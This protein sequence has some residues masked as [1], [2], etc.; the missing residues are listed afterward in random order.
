MYSTLK[1]V[2]SRRWLAL[3]GAVAAL[4]VA[5]A[6][7]GGS[8]KHGAASG[9]T[10]ATTASSSARSFPELR[11]AWPAIDHLDP[12]L[13]YGGGFTIVYGVYASLLS[14]RHANGPDG[15]ELVPALAEAL[16]KI[17]TDGRTY[18]FTLRD[19]LHYSDGRP[20]KA[21]D[22]RYG[23][24][25]LFRVNSPG[26]G[27]YSGI[28]GADAFAKHPDAGHISGIAVD[29]AARTVTFRLTQ[30]SG[31]FLSVIALPF[32]APVPTGTPAKDQS[33][34]PIPASGPYR[35]VSYDPSRSFVLERNPRYT[36]VDGV[37]A[38]NARRVTGTIVG[39]PSRAVE[40]AIDDKVDWDANDVPADR[41]AD[42]QRTHA[43]QLKP[44]EPS[45]T[46]MFFMNERLKPFNDVRVRQ[47]VNYAIDRDVFVKL[48]G[49]LATPTQNMLPPTYPS[50]RRIDYYTHDVARARRLVADA[51]ATGTQVR[52]LGNSGDAFSRKAVTYL[53][54]VLQQI[55]LRPEI[56]L[57]D[58]SVY[59]DAEGSPQTKA[60]I[61]W[62]PWYHDYPHPLDW[63]GVMVDGSVIRNTGNTNYSFVNIPALN[64]EIA[65]LRGKSQLTPEVNAAWAEL[66]RKT[67]V[68]EAAYAPFANLLKANLFGPRVDTSCTI[69]L[70]VFRFD[71]TTACVKP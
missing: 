63:F 24:E 8:S 33:T 35:I 37:P 70:S 60:N 15:T 40:L 7:C 14:Y 56:K 61:G 39:D 48:A 27:F 29:D 16:P 49:G 67:I 59:F 23:I 9:Q 55:G 51:G 53:A 64:Q 65:R 4:A 13:S 45:D 3:V 47:A 12:A 58:A 10:S 36:A 31:D 20:I 66:D 21:S 1:H 52:V 28:E 54:D 50:Y 6:G 62:T 11:V 42:L 69:N 34:S 19:G 18:T 22:V 2:A 17:S 26:V 44:Y 32:A 68:D 5:A 57:L 38:G 41:I 30:P 43:N 25:R 46:Q 71:W